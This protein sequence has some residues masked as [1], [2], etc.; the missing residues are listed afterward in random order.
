MELYL[1]L[2][3]GGRIILAANADM[4]DGQKLLQLIKRHHVSLVQATPAT[5]RLLIAAGWDKE[6]PI[7]VISTGEAL[8]LD[9]AREL[10]SRSDEVWDM[11]GPTETTVHSTAYQLEAPDCPILIG[12]PLGNT[13]VYILDKQQKLVPI[14]VPGEL[15][16][17]GDG[18]TH[19]YLGRP[20]LTQERFV[21]NPFSD[22]PESKL[23]RTG[24]LVR[25]LPDGN[26]E[27]F[28]RL[29]NQVKI[30]GFR[31]E[32]GE[33][34]TAM[35][36]FPGVRQ[37]A[38]V[39]REDMPGGKALV[40]YLVPNPDYAAAGDDAL[41]TSQNRTMITD[42]RQYLRGK[43][44]EYM[45]P[46]RFATIDALPL[47]PNG[48]VDRQALPQPL[49][50]QVGTEAAYAPPRNDLET[51][52]ATIWA[53][54]LG[55]PQVG[56]YDDFFELGGHSLI[57]IQIVVRINKAF[58]IELPMGSVFQLPTVAALTQDVVARQ[59]I[60]ESEAILEATDDADQ[61]EFTF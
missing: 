42:L 15:Y 26:L 21:P 23:Y 39:V 20:D 12:K 10:Q 51:A 55:L 34:E 7:R 25:Y 41:E 52:V 45:V 28:R 37:A 47:T 3:Q 49:E 61:E 31:I 6:T 8:P 11:Y 48:K 58:N 36:Q 29:D 27:Y 18:V 35:N 30:R 33:I 16:I 50:A 9:L 2:L 13:Q 59:Y 40:G 17:G 19:G 46:S 24:D 5:W 57:A 53:E 14:G 4:V 60:T 43:L 56:I 38:A 32:L 44:P 54:V 1:P 22:K